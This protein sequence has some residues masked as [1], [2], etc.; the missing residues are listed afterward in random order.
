MHLVLLHYVCSVETVYFCYH[1][2]LCLFFFSIPDCYEGSLWELRETVCFRMLCLSSPKSNRTI[3]YQLQYSNH[4]RVLLH[5]VPVEFTACLE[6]CFYTVETKWTL[7]CY[8]MRWLNF[9]WKLNV[10]FMPWKKK[11]TSLMTVVSLILYDLSCWEGLF[12]FIF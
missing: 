8:S 12:V 11:R 5:T 6:L 2:S 4:Q 10:F 3:A 9:R 1:F 7:V